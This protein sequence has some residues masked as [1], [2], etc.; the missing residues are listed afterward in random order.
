MTERFEEQ[1]VAALCRDGRADIRD[2]AAT[3]DV[4]PT[5]IQKH[6]RALEER[7]TIDGYTAQLNYGELGYGTAVFRLGVELDV[8]DDVTD[9]LRERAQ[10]VTVYQTS[11]P[12][13]VFAIGKFESEAAIAA[14]LR[15]LHDDP[16]IH[17]VEAD[18]VVSVRREDDCPIP[19]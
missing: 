5:T 1:L 15:E 8:I 3:T 16:D 14:C 13:P 7:G 12:H 9:R 2:I 17:R 10:F 18:T 4:V 19:E 6:L 11:G